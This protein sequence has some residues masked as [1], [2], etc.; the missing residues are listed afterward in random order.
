MVH[1]FDVAT[2]DGR[3][4]R[5]QDLWQRRELLLISLAGDAPPSLAAD[6][7]ARV[8][9]AAEVVVTTSAIEGVPQPGAVVADR[10]GEIHHVTTIDPTAPDL[11]DLVEWVRF[12]RM[13]CPECQGEAR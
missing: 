5:Y 10:W 12:V 7:R 2:T 8:G 4:V 1:F 9:S 3:R 11:D 13:Q 6:L